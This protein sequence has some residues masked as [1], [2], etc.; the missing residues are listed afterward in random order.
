MRDRGMGS[1]GGFVPEPSPR[2]TAPWIPAKG[3]PLERFTWPDDATG[4]WRVGAISPSGA[5]P[6]NPHWWDA[7]PDPA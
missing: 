1:I 2:G 3:E 7:H 4:K 6:P 5:A